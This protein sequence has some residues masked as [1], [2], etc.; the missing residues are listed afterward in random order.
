MK[1]ASLLGII[2][3]VG[4]IVS[5]FLP[6]AYYPDIDQT[7]T[8]FY[9]FENVYGKPGKA[10]IFFAVVCIIL[11]LIPRIWAKRVNLFFTALAMAYGVKTYA[12]Y[13]G[14]YRGVCPETRY[15]IWLMLIFFL[16]MLICAIFPSGKVKQ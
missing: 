14:C 12:M 16:V 13:S 11:S 9:T 6:W 4:L 15:G 1:Y 8:G 5:C 10:I 3:A 2:A 7:F